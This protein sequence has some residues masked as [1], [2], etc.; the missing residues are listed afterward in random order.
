MGWSF[1]A[2][3]KKALIQDRVKG[4]SNLD[5]GTRVESLAHSIRGNVLWIVRRAILAD[6]TEADRWIECDLIE[7]DRS[8]QSWGY[9]DMDEG[10]HPYYYSCPVSYLDMVPKVA[11]QEWRDKVR[12]HHAPAKRKLKIGTWYNTVPGCN[13]KALRV[14][15]IKPL[16][17][18]GENGYVYRCAKKIFAE[19]IPDPTAP[20]VTDQL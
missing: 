16:R 5:N 2:S 4:W 1:Y 9:K 7:K 18:Q 19:E 10:M 17:A 8:D 15:S 6:G 20:V 3:D 12:E 14:V 11:C 13:V